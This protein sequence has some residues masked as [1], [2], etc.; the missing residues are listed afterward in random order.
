MSVEFF[1]DTNVFIY[2][3][4]GLD[5]RKQSIADAVVDDA[6]GNGCISF[7]VVQECLN[8]IVRKAEIPL[9][10][11]EAQ[12]YLE[13]VLSPLWFVMP[14]A[15]FYRRGIDIQSRYQYGFY[16]SLIIAAALEAG[17]KRL[18]SEDMQ[19]GQRIGR[20]TIENPFR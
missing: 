6:I 9:T 13:S 15:G 12:R 19:H 8:T 4:E 17:C 18:L 20:L 10:S 2:Q 14:S 7:Q 3:L 16:D 1:V 5:A 11:A